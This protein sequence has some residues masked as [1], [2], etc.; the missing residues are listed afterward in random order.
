MDSYL[1]WSS[2]PTKKEKSIRLNY[3]IRTP[4]FNLDPV[5]VVVYE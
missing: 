5:K 2:I 4:Y 1:H 3:Q